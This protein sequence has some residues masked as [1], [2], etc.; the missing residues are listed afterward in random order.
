M[1]VFSSIMLPSYLVEGVFLKGCVFSW[2]SAYNFYTT[3]DVMKKSCLAI[4]MAE[5]P[6]FKKNKKKWLKSH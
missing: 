3:Y 5:N 1:C 2:I 4:L 6:P